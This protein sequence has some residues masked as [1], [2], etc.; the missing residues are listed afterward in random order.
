M[1]YGKIVNVSS[2][3]A[4]SYSKTASVEYTSSKYGLIGLTKQLAYKYGKYNLN[5]NCICPSQTE[6]EMLLKNLTKK[7]I[8]KIEEQIP[9]GR[10]AKPEQIADL[11]YFLSSDYSNYINGSVIDINAGQI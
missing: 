10:I 3:A 1:K 9:L 6:T 7:Q 11:V 8:S 2:I 4:R 5:I